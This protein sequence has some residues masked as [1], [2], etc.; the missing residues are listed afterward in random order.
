MIWLENSLLMLKNSN[1][2]D[3]CLLQ[4][5]NNGL[6]LFIDRLKQAKMR[7]NIQIRFAISRAR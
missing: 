2:L 3:K 7:K 6:L 4:V 1:A 5:K